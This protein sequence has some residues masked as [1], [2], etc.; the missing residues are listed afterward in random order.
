MKILQEISTKSTF[1]IV[2][3]LITGFC[4]AQEVSYLGDNLVKNFSISIENNSD[5]MMVFKRPKSTRII[6]NNSSFEAILNKDLEILIQPKTKVEET[7]SA[8]SINFK[9]APK[10]SSSKL[11]LTNELGKEYLDLLLKVENKNLWGNKAQIEF[12]NLNNGLS[13]DVNKKFIHSYHSEIKFESNS[14]TKIF[15]LAMIDS[16]VIDTLLSKYIGRGEYLF[17]Y[18]KNSLADIN[19]KKAIRIIDNDGQILYQSGKKVMRV[20]KMKFLYV[21]NFETKTPVSKASLEVQDIAGKKVVQLLENQKIKIGLWSKSITFDYEGLES[22]TVKLCL[23][24]NKGKIIDEEKITYLQLQELAKKGLSEVKTLK[25]SHKYS[26]KIAENHVRCTL[27]SEDKKVL[28][29]IF[30]D[31][32]IHSGINKVEY[33]YK[34]HNVE[35]E[36]VVLYLRTPSGKVISRREYIIN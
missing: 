4:K 1:F 20:Q 7:F 12:W 13:L 27:E 10:D 28:V 11:F 33:Y 16:V 36:T 2:I 26:S 3:M 15:V 25:I 21:Y 30:E 31:K 34:H 14:E 8:L 5:T 24:N 32:N 22:D 23:K 19:G 17:R 6:S 18:E 35:G 9:Y 29:T